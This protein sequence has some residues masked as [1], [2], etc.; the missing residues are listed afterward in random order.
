MI[1]PLNQ[2]YATW[3]NSFIASS[4]KF[5][6]ITHTLPVKS[7]APFLISVSSG[8]RS[9]WNHPPSAE[10]TIPLARKTSPNALPVES[11]PTISLSSSSVNLYAVSTPQLVNTS[12]A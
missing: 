11:L 8:T 5:E 9:K 6:P 3:N 2:G 10:A 12:S 7:A 1:P 4:F